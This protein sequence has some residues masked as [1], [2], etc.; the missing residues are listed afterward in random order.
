MKRVRGLQRRTAFTNAKG[1]TNIY[2]LK[3]DFTPVAFDFKSKFTQKIPSN[4]SSYPKSRDCGKLAPLFDNISNSTLVTKI[5]IYFLPLISSKIYRL[6]EIR[7]STKLQSNPM[8]GFNDSTFSLVFK[9]HVTNANKMLHHTGGKLMLTTRYKFS[10]KP[11][12]YRICVKYLGI[13]DRFLAR[14]ISNKSG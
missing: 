4:N 9:A 12:T 1:T 2:A 7:L 6:P 8:P 10:Y 3:L 13:K 14:N 11:F 5:I